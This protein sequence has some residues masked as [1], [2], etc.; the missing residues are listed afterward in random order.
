MEFVFNLFDI[1]LIS[2]DI[3]KAPKYGNTTKS[4]YCRSR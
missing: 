4:H 3:I 2:I 1:E